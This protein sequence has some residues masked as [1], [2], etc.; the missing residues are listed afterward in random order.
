LT[1]RFLFTFSYILLAFL[2]LL[3]IRCTD[4]A[5][6]KARPDVKAAAHCHSINGKAWSVFGKPI[7]LLTQDSCIFH[8][9][10]V[11][12]LWFQSPF[13]RQLKVSLSTV[14]QAVYGNFGGIVLAQEEGENIAAALG[15]KVSSLFLIRDEQSY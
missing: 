10:L 3:F 9:N 4:S 14:S 12:L 13:D 5:I 11:S 8:D 6:H 1:F 2:S 15:P 7:D